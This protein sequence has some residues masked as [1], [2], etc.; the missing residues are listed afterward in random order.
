LTIAM[1]LIQAAKLNGIDP[2]AWLAD[3][4]K[5]IVSGLTKVT[6][7]DTPLWRNWTLNSPAMI[8]AIVAL[9]PEINQRP[10]STQFCGCFRCVARYPS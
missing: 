5:R 10:T 1:P 9:L 4:L 6:R 2:Q 7:L 8:L 3:V